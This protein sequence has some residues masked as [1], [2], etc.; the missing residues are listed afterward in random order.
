M[1][2]A[3]RGGG[4][5]GGGDSRAAGVN[6]AL[7]TISAAATAIAAVEN[8][9][10]Q[11][12]SVQKRRWGGCWSSYW[13]FGSHNNRKRIGHA[14][15]GPESSN[16]PADVQSHTQT[17]AIVL[18]FVAPP[19]SPASFFQSEPPSVTQSPS[20]LLSLNSV[21]ASMYSPRGPHSIFA[22]G[23]YANETQL[24]SPPV[25][26]AFTTE[27]STAPFT[28][29]PESV[30][31]TTPSSPEV[32]F[33]QLLDP[34][35]RNGNGFLG[36]PFCQYEFPFYQLSPGS[37]MGH[38]ISPGSGFSVSGTSSPFAGCEL[39]AI[40]PNFLD[41]LANKTP[42]LLELENQSAHEWGSRPD[43]GSLTPD[44]A[45]PQSRDGS[46]RDAKV[47][48]YP[49]LHEECRNDDAM[50][51]NQ[52]ESLELPA[53]EVERCAEAEAIALA[54]EVTK[55]ESKCAE[56]EI[57]TCTG[58]EAPTDHEK[59]RQHRR[60][61]SITLGSS[62]DFNFDNTDEQDATSKPKTGSASCTGEK[63]LEEE[64]GPTKNWSFFPAIH[65]GV[66]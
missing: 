21:S 14:I 24:V 37:P 58:G 56:S 48:P 16:P 62:R 53:E 27:P 38:L 23:P 63:V 1:R 25:F 30:H 59:I 2:N 32:P 55:E 6:A 19:S 9:A 45:R 13:C 17:T 36:F 22:I 8:R 57:S 61:R 51:G 3:R 39:P 31:M 50:V 64:N 29:P 47:A 52:K 41:F 46:L 11:A 18:P 60:Y 20:G 44:A 4:G 35:P 26:S 5:G 34:N 49:E 66:S 10:P 42:K 28:P 15:L 43:S 65:S 40:P 12:T 7:E 54:K 33:A